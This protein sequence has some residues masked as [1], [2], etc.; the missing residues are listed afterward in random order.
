MITRKR[1][2]GVRK[3]IHTPRTVAVIEPTGRLSTSGGGRKTAPPRKPRRSTQRWHAVRFLRQ[4]ESMLMVA[5][6]VSLGI[7][8]WFSPCTQLQ[9]VQV[10][11]VP[12]TAR[13]ALALELASLG[14]AHAALSHL[15]RRMEQKLQRLGWVRQVS[16]QPQTPHRALLVVVPREPLIE[17]RYHGGQKR[18]LD[19]AGFLFHAPKTPEKVPLGV[20]EIAYP[21]EPHVDGEMKHPVIQRAFA[22]LHA[23]L[24]AHAVQ[25]AQVTIHQTGELVLSC[26]LRQHALRLTFRLGDALALPQ[27]LRLI[28]TLLAHPKAE[29]AHW[30]YIDI[31]SPSAPAIKRKAGGER[32]E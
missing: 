31:K 16:W 9:V 30:E 11:G 20:I 8:V 10:M 27:Q 15:P 14:T 19:S 23:L 25:H 6:L 13:T 2:K 18:Y 4:L 32:D 5:I 29:M 3:R 7:S 28:H 17:V 1:P 22:L 21:T 24:E 26:Q 12:D